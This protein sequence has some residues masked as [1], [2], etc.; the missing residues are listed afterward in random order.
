MSSKKPTQGQSEYT[1]FKQLGLANVLGMNMKLVQKVFD[2]YPRC[3]QKYFHIDLTAGSGFNADCNTDGSPL[4]F[5]SV[6]ASKMDYRAFFCDI[7]K[8]S[9]GRLKRKLAGDRNSFVFYGDYASLL[10][11]APDLIASPQVIGFKQNPEYAYGTVYLDPNGPKLISDGMPQLADFFA[12]CPRMDFVVNISATA[13]KRT[14]HFN[15]S[16][17]LQDLMQNANKA[18]WQI[19][20]VNPGDKWQWT[21]LIGRNRRFS[22]W[23][24]EGFYEVNS[25]TGALILD[26]LSK[27]GGPMF[28]QPQQTELAL[29]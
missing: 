17:T 8:D 10:T 24:R 14:S 25:P 16:Y 18:H 20:A 5:K 26:G 28:I 1:P 12:A 21:I 29:I 3:Q 19:K 23:Q 22:G 2:K 9:C 11:V 27:R 7:R 15:W 6:V 4:I 13:L